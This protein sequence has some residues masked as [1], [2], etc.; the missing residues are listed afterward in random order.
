M[1]QVLKQLPTG[2]KTEESPEKIIDTIQVWNEVKP[3][4]TIV[5]EVIGKNV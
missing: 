2:K 5:V 3:V 1:H 4:Y